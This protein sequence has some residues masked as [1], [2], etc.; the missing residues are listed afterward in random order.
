MSKLLNNNLKKN[1]LLF[2]QKKISKKQLLEILIKI[3]NNNNI[4]KDNYEIIKNIINNNLKTNEKEELLKKQQEELRKKQQEELLKKQKE[5]E[6]LKKQK[7]EE[8]LKKQKEEELIFNPIFEKI[9][10]NCNCCKNNNN[11][12]FD[13]IYC[14][15]ICVNCRKENNIKKKFIDSNG[16]IINNGE[17]IELIDYDEIILDGPIIVNPGGSLIIDADNKKTLITKKEKTAT[18]IIL[19]K[20]INSIINQELLKIY[21]INS[22]YNSLN[23]N[24]VEEDG[25]IKLNNLKFEFIS[26]KLYAL[27][28]IYIFGV[29]KGSITNIILNEYLGYGINIRKSNIYIDNIMDNDLKKINTNKSIISKFFFKDLIF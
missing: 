25:Y 4:N 26:N 15:C 10:C 18:I 12:C 6:L 3:I 22:V 17:K 11:E 28:S 8:L 14:N 20:N 27:H 23:F 21:K 5:E 1:I 24:N 29:T 2:N 19:G 16:L 9:N 13:N 7:E